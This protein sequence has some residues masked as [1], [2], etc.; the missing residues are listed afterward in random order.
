[1]RG[2]TGGPGVPNHIR[3]P[4]ETIS[5]KTYQNTNK[6][7]KKQKRSTKFRQSIT[8]TFKH[9]NNTKQSMSLARIALAS[10]WLG[11][12]I[13]RCLLEPLHQE[14]DACVRAFNSAKVLSITRTIW[15]ASDPNVPA[16]QLKDIHK[17][18]AVYVMESRVGLAKASVGIILPMP[19]VCLDGVRHYPQ[20]DLSF[21]AQ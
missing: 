20:I 4:I 2:E 18:S 21:M 9:G 17:S 12:R 6:D 5:R 10:P 13:H 7:T 1:M 11:G 3:D 19:L 15:A 8:K 14:R 16:P